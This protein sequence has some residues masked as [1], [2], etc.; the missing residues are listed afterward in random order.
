MHLVT[1][2]VNLKKIL[3]N[4]NIIF[5]LCVFT[6]TYILYTLFYWFYRTHIYI[7]EAIDDKQMCENLPKQHLNRKNKTGKLLSSILCFMN[8]VSSS[9]P[10]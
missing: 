7:Y 5:K 8:N 6:Y 10:R 9:I 2:H 1:L 4:R 3:T